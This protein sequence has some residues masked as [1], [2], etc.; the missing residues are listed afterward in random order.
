VIFFACLVRIVF[1]LLLWFTLRPC[2]SRDTYDPDLPQL[3]V[4]VTHEDLVI[5]VNKLTDKFIQSCIDRYHDVA[6]SYEAEDWAQNVQMQKRVSSYCLI[7]DY[8]FP[9]LFPVFIDILMW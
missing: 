4:D 9:V 1:D 8:S 5:H 6:S 7:F 3:E 2:Y